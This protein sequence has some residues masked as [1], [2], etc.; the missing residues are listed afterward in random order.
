MT[1][2]LERVAALPGTKVTLSAARPAV[3]DLALTLN[4]KPGKLTAAEAGR[5]SARFEL[6][7]KTRWELTAADGPRA[8]RLAGLLL[9]RTDTPPSVRIDWPRG[10]VVLKQLK[11]LRLAVTAADDFG[12]SESVAR[13]PPGRREALAAAGPVR[14]HRPPAED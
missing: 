5:E 8:T 1:A 9:L 10:D 7:G 12:L 6:R 3:G 4:E 14:R 11:P 13:V 2:G